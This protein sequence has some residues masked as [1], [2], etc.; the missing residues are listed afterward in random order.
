VSNY[1]PRTQKKL[2]RQERLEN[3]LRRL[4]VRGVCHE[5]LVFAAEEV[6][7]SRIRTIKAYRQHRCFIGSTARHDG[8]IAALQ[9]LPIDSILIE[10]GWSPSGESGNTRD[11][12]RA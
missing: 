1:L 11:S 6:R 7:A 8:E 10:F 9:A 3:D 2:E 4:I 5:E 12:A